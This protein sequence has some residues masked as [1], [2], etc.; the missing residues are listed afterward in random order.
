MESAL[1][2]RKEAK[3]DFES[4]HRIHREAFGRTAEADLVNTMRARE[5]LLLSLVAT[6]GDKVVGHIAFSPISFENI[7][8]HVM[9]VSLAPM[10][11]LPN[12]QRQGIGTA[13][14]RAGVIELTKTGYSSIFVLGH[15]EYYTKNGFTL[16]H[17]HGIVSEYPATQNYFFC[18][19]L[20]LHALRG[21]QGVAKYS[22][23]FLDISEATTRNL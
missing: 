5:E 22:S 9:A 23:A 11:V 20:Q 21:I 7:P 14:I 6:L 19:E 10:A 3:P 12:N 4:I 13:M 2:I 8:E 16:A 17:K 1:I 18:K 15:P